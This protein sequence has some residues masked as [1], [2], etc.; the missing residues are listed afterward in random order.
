M[1][2]RKMIRQVV[3][4]MDQRQREEDDRNEA[5][6]NVECQSVLGSGVLEG[7]VL[8]IALEN[9]TKPLALAELES[10]ERVKH[11]CNALYEVM[12]DEF[13]PAFLLVTTRRL[14]WSVSPKPKTIMSMHFDDVVQVSGADYHSGTRP[15]KAIRLTYRPADFPTPMRRFNPSG[16]L[17]ATFAFPQA[18]D[19]IRMSILART[20][21]PGPND[22]DDEGQVLERLRQLSNDVTA[23]S[24]CPICC[25]DLQQMTES[26]MQCTSRRHLFSAPG[27]EPVIDE[28][29]D[30]FGH[31]VDQSRWL[32]FL[33]HHLDIVDFPLIW[34]VRRE[35][36][37]G[38]P[39]ILDYQT[40]RDAWGLGQS[41]D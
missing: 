22:D 6:W 39:K 4:E 38:P 11:Q 37:F 23:W 8:A 32:P 30:N 31:I 27:V 33:E 41:E 28:G 7:E 35:S 40:M 1:R 21:H 2:R 9:L 17:D 10:S 29:D 25:H 19:L 24:L 3:A 16:E 15:F 26:T 36:P 34:L 13:L 20:G 5:E 14:I 12:P 18:L